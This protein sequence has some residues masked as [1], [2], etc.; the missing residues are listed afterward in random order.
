MHAER[1]QS[2]GGQTSLPW[3]LSR[4]VIN[5]VDLAGVEIARNPAESVLAN[6]QVQAARATRILAIPVRSR[7][8]NAVTCGNGMRKHDLGTHRE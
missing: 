6:R 8:L 2:V 5:A 4:S 1:R 7:A 3:W